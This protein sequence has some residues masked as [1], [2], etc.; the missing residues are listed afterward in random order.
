MYLFARREEVGSRCPLSLSLSLSLSF[1]LSCFFFFSLSLSVT[2]TLSTHNLSFLSLTHSLSLFHHPPHEN[3]ETKSS[4]DQTSLS[5]ANEISSKDSEQNL[6]PPNSKGDGPTSGGDES[7]GEEEEEGEDE[8]DDE[9]E[10]DDEGEEEEKEKGKGKEREKNI[11]SEKNHIGGG[12]SSPNSPR[13]GSKGESDDEV[14]LDDKDMV[15][16]KE[17]D[18]ELHDPTIPL[19]WNEIEKYVTYQKKI[20]DRG[21]KAKLKNSEYEKEDLLIR[22]QT[23]EN[24]LEE[25]REKLREERDKNTKLWNRVGEIRRHLDRMSKTTP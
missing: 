2:H 25:G 13:S 15:I 23:L 5:N 22:V 20:I 1:A 17:E 12:V 18:I 9:E 6:K 19:L 3:S 4:S 8:G 7:N 14:E 11:K 24:Q 21:W 16:E 10:D